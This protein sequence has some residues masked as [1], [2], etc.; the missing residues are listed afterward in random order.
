MLHTVTRWFIKQKARRH[1]SAE[2]LRPLVGIRFQV[3]FH[4]PLG[5]LFTFP[6]RYWFTIGHRRVFS[7]TR[8]SS[9]IHTRFLVSRATRETVQKIYSFRLRGYH[10][11][12]PDFPV[13]STK[14]KFFNFTVC[15]QADKTAPTTPNVQRPPP[16]T[17]IKFRLMQF[18]SPLLMQSLFYFLF[19]GVLRCFNSPRWRLTDYVFISLHPGITLDRLSHS[20]TPG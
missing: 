8:W 3:L 7:L 9:Q 20:E 16:I 6:S 1:H 12:W 19:L 15:R 14:S 18:R 10:P 13:R 5:V 2:W 17:H 4:S 11:L